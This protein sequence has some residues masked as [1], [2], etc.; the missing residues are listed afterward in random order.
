MGWYRMVA[1]AMG[2]EIRGITERKVKQAAGEADDN[3]DMDINPLTGEV[4]DIAGS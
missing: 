4:T 2:R 3:K 1:I